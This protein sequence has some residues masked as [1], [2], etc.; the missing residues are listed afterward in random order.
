MS[1]RIR[2][3]H[4]GFRVSDLEASIRWYGEAFGAKEA[5]RGHN[6]DGSVGLV[7]VEFDTGDFVEFFPNG[8]NRIER[9]PDPIGYAHLCF[10]VDNLDQT[11]AHL[12]S[13]GV[14]GATN[15]PRNGRFGQ[16]F[17]F[18]GDPDGNRIE[19]TEIPETSPLYRT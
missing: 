1:G 10:T 8:K 16:R 14:E 4:A 13:L 18:V 15:A 17:A 11:L 7:F 19:L 6:E 9:P 12:A 5:F 2:Y 3:H